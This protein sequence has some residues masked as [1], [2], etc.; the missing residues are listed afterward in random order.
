[1]LFS[2]C[3]YSIHFIL[4]FIIILPLMVVHFVGILLFLWQYEYKDAK[5]TPNCF[6][7]K[8][9]CNVKPS[10]YKMYVVLV[11]TLKYH[12]CKQLKPS[13]HKFNSLFDQMTVKAS[14]VILAASC[15]FQINFKCSDLIKCKLKLWR[16]NLFSGEIFFRKCYLFLENTWEYY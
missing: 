2:W 7:L 8:W 11:V 9:Y 10:N 16:I 13:K 5:M 1:M 14:N 15:L 12:S 6:R 3:L 4:H